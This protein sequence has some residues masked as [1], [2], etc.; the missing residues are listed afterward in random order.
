MLRLESMR[1]F[2]A[3][4]AFFG[5]LVLTFGIVRNALYFQGQSGSGMS[6]STV[7]QNKNIAARRQRN[8]YTASLNSKERQVGR[9]PEPVTRADV[10]HAVQRELKTRGYEP[11][12]ADGVAGILTRAAVMAYEYDNGRQISG[13]PSNEFLEFLLLGSTGNRSRAMAT[14]QNL[15]E[16]KNIVVSVQK[17][18]AEHGYAPGRIDG[19]LGKATRR[20]I[21]DFERD[22][23]LAVKGRISGKLIEEMNKV[24]GVAVA[25]TTTAR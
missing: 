2:L 6:S 18:L 25:A 12:P 21:K 23:G 10:V 20:A 14:R 16:A 3:R 9:P 4:A 1:P 22:R 15:P 17:K 19:V 13:D 5:L 11:G 24:M 8:P 7:G